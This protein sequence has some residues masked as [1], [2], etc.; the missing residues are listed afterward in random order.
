MLGIVRNVIAFIVKRLRLRKEKRKPQGKPRESAQ[1]AGPQPEQAAEHENPA[2]SVVNE[3]K[4]EE[5]E[6]VTITRKRT[7]SRSSSGPAAK[8]VTFDL[9]TVE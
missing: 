2:P 3:E 6:Q 4:S 8:K 7:R 1:N 5:I 9:N